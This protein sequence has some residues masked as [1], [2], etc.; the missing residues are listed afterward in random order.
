MPIAA[1]RVSVGTTEVR[2]D[3]IAEMKSALGGSM[4]IRN[5]GGGTVFIGEKGVTT[6]TGF[7]LRSGEILS[8]AL[9]SW[10]NVFAI[11]ATTQTLQILHARSGR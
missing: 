11:A 2:L 3:S 5:T 8:I 4:M 6:S 10:V 7:E 9:D 1:K